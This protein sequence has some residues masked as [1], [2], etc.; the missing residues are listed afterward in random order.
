MNI[1]IH[2]GMNTADHADNN[3]SVDLTKS[4]K[5]QSKLIAKH[6]RIA[7]NIIRNSYNHINYDNIFKSYNDFSGYKNNN[8]YA[9]GQSQDVPQSH[10]FGYKK[11]GSDAAVVLNVLKEFLNDSHNEG[12]LNNSDELDTSKGLINRFK[13]IP[14]KDES[15]KVLIKKYFNWYN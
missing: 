8:D 14:N 12:I 7:N 15:P 9:F 6:E 13:L 10:K 1:I 3:T 2:I 11:R 4:F 5:P